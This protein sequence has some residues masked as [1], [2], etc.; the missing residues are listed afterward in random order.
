M[1]PIGRNKNVAKCEFRLSKELNN[2]NN[3]Y[4]SKKKNSKFKK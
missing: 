2:N 4:N 1:R 3:N